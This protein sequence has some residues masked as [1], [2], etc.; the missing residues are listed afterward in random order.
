MKNYKF[1]INGNP[2]EVAIDSLDD[3]N[4][5]VE[6]NGITYDVVIEQ[7]EKQNTKPARRVAQANQASA[8]ASS[9]EAS[10]G[11]T[12]IFGPPSFSRSTR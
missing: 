3:T 7:S 12:G 2:Y 9:F 5:K 1:K 8:S 4:A 11:A 10:T 6:V